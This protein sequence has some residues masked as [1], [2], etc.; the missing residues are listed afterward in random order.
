MIISKKKLDEMIEQARR[1]QSDKDWNRQQEENE[2]R[3]MWH[4]IYELRE[5]LDKLEGKQ[6]EVIP[7]DPVRPAR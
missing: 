7:C 5:R 4:V 3:D 1:E 6:P 2:K